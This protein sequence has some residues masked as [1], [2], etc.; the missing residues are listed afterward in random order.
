MP[1]S[2]PRV[3]LQLASGS[4]PAALPAQFRRLKDR[5][6]DLFNGIDGYLAQEPGR[7]RLLIG[8]FR[9]AADARTFADDLGSVDIPASSWTNAPGQ[10]VT[11]L[12]PQ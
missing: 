6:R 10:Q 7:A 9:N 2:R 5:N 1:A 3:W 8:P 4:D 11:K 12:P